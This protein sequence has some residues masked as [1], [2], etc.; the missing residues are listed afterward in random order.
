[1]EV[2]YN[3]VTHSWHHSPHR[4][5]G[6]ICTTWLVV[7]WCIQDTS[8]IQRQPC[9]YTQCRLQNFMSTTLSVWCVWLFCFTVF[10]FTCYTLFY[11]R[12]CFL[13][14]SSKSSRSLFL[15]MLPT[16]RRWLLWDMVTP[17]L[18][19]F[20]SSVSFSWKCTTFFRGEERLYHVEKHL[21]SKAHIFI[22]DTCKFCELCNPP[23]RLQ[24]SLQTLKNTLL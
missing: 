4:T 20:C 11:V 23:A 3:N 9:A 1:M 5:L 19:P 15:G 18:L 24:M 22:L 21:S 17:I 14:S 10:A 8:Y 12:A 13:N 16:K 6:Y 7:S 2:Q